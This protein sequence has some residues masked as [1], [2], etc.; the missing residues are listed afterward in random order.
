MM[1]TTWSSCLDAGKLRPSMR[2][3]SSRARGRGDY[4]DNASGYSTKQNRNRQFK[5]VRT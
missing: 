1:K 4:V 2:G 3:S 5:I